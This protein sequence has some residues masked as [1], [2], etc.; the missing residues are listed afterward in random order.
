MSFTCAC[1]Y[2]TDVNHHVSGTQ[3]PKKIEKDPFAFDQSYHVD[4]C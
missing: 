1:K 4:I 2:Q 3:S